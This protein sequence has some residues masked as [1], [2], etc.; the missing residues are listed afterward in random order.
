M[1]FQGEKYDWNKITGWPTTKCAHLKDII[2][3]K[4]CIC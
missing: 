1:A 4:I 2:I 3:L